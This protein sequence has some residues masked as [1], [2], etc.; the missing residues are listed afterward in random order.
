LKI[1]QASVVTVELDPPADGEGGDIKTRPAVVLAVDADEVTC[2]VVGVSKNMV[3]GDPGY[4]V[5]M[6]FSD[7]RSSSSGNSKSGL[8]EECVAKCYWYDTV[9]IAECK[10]IGHIPTK[11]IAEILRLVEQY[12]NS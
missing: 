4:F 10:S 2:T 6:P 3:I 11:K 5:K 12:E 9:L 7:N 1:R 8:F